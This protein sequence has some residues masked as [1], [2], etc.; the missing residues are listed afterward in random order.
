MGFTLYQ[1]L[2]REKSDIVAIIRKFTY[3]IDD[4][5]YVHVTE[6]IVAKMVILDVDS[7]KD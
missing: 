1:N 4:T 3:I 7:S 5:K 6:T 2:R